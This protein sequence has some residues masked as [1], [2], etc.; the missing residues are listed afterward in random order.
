MTRPRLLQHWA[1][2]QATRR[3]SAVA[4]SSGHETLTYA[5]LDA[6][7]TQLARVLRKGGC[8]R[9]RCNTCPPDH[10]SLPSK[11]PDQRAEATG[12]KFKS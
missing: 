8:Q 4:V 11:N 6:L 7:S 9:G 12:V 3:P 10:G 5:E 2:E 1:S